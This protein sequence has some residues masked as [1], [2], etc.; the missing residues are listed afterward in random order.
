MKIYALIPI[1]EAIVKRRFSKMGQ[2]MTKKR[3]TLDDNSLETL[4]HIS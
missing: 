3:N 1:S 4:M 2:I